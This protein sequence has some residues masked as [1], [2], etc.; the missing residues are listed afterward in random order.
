MNHQQ[1]IIYGGVDTHL[2]VHAAVVM[3]HAGTFQATRQFPTSPQ[4]L[5]GLRR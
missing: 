1:R 4:G 2:D 5:R 3:D